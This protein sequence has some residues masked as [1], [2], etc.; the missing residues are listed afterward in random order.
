MTKFIEAIA[1]L[2]K[3]Q[4]ESDELNEHYDSQSIVEQIMESC[5]KTRD[6]ELTEEEFIDW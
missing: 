2:N 6:D 3:T 5:G 4:T 1:E